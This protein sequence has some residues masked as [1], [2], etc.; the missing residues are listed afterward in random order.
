MGRADQFFRDIPTMPKEKATKSIIYGLL[1][2][3][4]FS[5]IMA[6]SMSIAGNAATWQTWADYQNNMGFWD[7]IYGYSEWQRNGVAIQDMRNWMAWQNV[8]FGNLAKIGV[9]IG[10]LLIVIG[11]I[12][13]AVND[14]LDEKTRQISL[15]LAGVI[16]FIVM[17]SLFFQNVAVVIQYT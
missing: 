13:F 10:L 7:G 6:T 3:I 17:M 8:I 16:L 15:V 5:L 2:A 1:I 14:Q 11:F 9:S 4:I 12:G